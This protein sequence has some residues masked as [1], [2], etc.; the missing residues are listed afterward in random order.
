MGDFVLCPSGRGLIRSLN[1]ALPYLIV[2][3]TYNALNMIAMETCAYSPLTETPGFGSFG[4]V[5][6][7]VGMTMTS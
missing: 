2:E 6:L 1:V 4:G 5:N 7:M 3:K